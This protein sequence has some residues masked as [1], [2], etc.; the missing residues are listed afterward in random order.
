VFLQHPEQGYTVPVLELLVQLLYIG[1]LQ[2]R[3]DLERF[4]IRGSL[5]GTQ[6]GSVSHPVSCLKYDQLQGQASLLKALSR[7]VLDRMETAQPL[8]T[9]WSTA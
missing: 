2:V 4:G 5:E 6:V 7:Q 1:F 3:C 8:W 9:A